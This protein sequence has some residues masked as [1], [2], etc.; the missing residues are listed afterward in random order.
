MEGLP[1]GR[2]DWI[3]TKSG[4]EAA[5]VVHSCAIL[6][7]AAPPLYSSDHYPVVAELALT[8]SD[9][10]GVAACRDAHRR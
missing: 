3:L 2:V 6:D 1:A 4:E 10:R 5:F 8:D 9:G 7:D